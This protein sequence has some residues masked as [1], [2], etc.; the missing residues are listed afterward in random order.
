MVFKNE[1][2][3]AVCE[4][5]SNKMVFY[6]TPTH[7]FIVHNWKVIM[8]V[9]DEVEKNTHKQFISPLPKF[10]EENFPFLLLSGES[11]FN[12]LNVQSGYMEPLVSAIT[13]VKEA[14][15]AFFF[16]VEQTQNHLDN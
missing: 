6:A 15:T 13:S 11:S 14:Q 9:K 7:L 3:V 2:C 8:T 1:A 10:H 4:Y 5:A 12:I 16:E